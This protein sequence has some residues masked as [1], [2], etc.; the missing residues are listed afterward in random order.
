MMEGRGTT[1]ARR[2]LSGLIHFGGHVFFI[3][4]DVNHKEFINFLT[5]KSPAEQPISAV[6]LLPPAI[7]FVVDKKRR[8]LKLVS[9]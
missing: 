8:G 6:C 9:V 4:Q 1:A 2:F 3:L 7:T 5:V